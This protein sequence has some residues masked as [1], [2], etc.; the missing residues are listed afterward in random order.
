M[1]TIL[2]ANPV[3]IVQNALSDIVILALPIP[4]VLNLR[5]SRKR[6]AAVLGIIC[7]GSLSV[8]T[9]LCRFSL[10]YQ[11]ATNPDTTYVMGRM[12]IAAAIEIEIAVVAVN[13]P[14]L[15]SL[16]TKFVGSTAPDYST[17]GGHKMSDYKSSNG[18]K[19]SGLSSTK[20]SARSQTLGA[21]LTG[22][23]EDLL[24]TTG[25]KEAGNITVTTNVDVASVQYNQGSG[26][27][28]THIGFPA[29]GNMINSINTTP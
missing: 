7:F 21:T 25:K 12:I 14:A 11:M 1:L 26:D 27:Y 2:F 24:R 4:T 29:S 19:G 6:K 22:S 17:N 23:E 28:P 3:S 16:F 5:M 8:V 20:K 15:K 10:Q 13:L 9:A 18:L